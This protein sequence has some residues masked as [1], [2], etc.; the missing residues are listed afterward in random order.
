MTEKRYCLD[1]NELAV[2]LA[3][4]GVRQL[5]S[6]GSE[7]NQLDKK[8]ICMSLHS[9][10]KSNLIEQENK[11]FVIEQGLKRN[12]GYINY[13]KVVLTVHI[14]DE[15]RIH[16]IC[17]YLARRIAVVKT[18]RLSKGKVSTYLADW[19]DILEEIIGDSQDKRMK[20]LLHKSHSGELIREELLEK[21]IGEEYKRNILMDYYE[22]GASL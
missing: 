4:Y 8:D 21:G 1:E 15:E 19:A 11:S 18:D 16:I 20:I 22:E 14:Y 13:S 10:Y 6:I 9:L 3:G 12:L 17:S 5:Y 2:L 7:D